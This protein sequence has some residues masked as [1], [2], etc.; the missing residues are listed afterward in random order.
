MDILA[1]HRH[2]IAAM[3]KGS[4]KPQGFT[5]IELLVVISII[6]LLSSIV[7]STLNVARDKAR[8]GAG[9]QFSA[10][11]YHAAGD[12][13]LGIWKMDECSGTTARDASG[14][15]NDGTLTGG[16]AFSTDTPSGKG[17]SADLAGSNRYINTG[18]NASFADISSELTV[19]GW[20]KIT[21]P[22]CYN[23]IFSND[24][25]FMS[26][27]Q[28]GFALG[29]YCSNQTRFRVRNGA[30]AQVTGPNLSNDV[31]Y[32]LAGVYDGSTL[33][34][35]IDGKLV[36]STAYSGGV[37][38]YPASWNGAIGNLGNCTT[39][40]PHGMLVDDVYIFAKSLVAAD[41]QKAYALGRPEASSVASR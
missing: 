14:S 4:S 36:A 31:W 19:M 6:S 25:D 17:C 24:H 40:A 20:I 8:V 34:L 15:G 26:G 41:I 27:T 3:R 1:Y 21:T 30:P 33:K 11:A 5:L 35:Y 28:N 10:N 39:C 22:H 9:Q 16:A 18:T 2:S 37:I 12:R 38:G 32:H 7:L 13:A 29:T 23:W